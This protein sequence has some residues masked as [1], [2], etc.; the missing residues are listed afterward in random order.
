MDFRCGGKS[1]TIV[2]VVK[3]FVFPGCLLSLIQ[4]LA[5]CVNPIGML[6]SMLG[7]ITITR[8]INEEKSL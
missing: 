3:D 8:H 6:L 2:Y 1:F 7:Q 5:L 4:S